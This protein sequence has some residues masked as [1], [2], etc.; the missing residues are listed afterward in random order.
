MNLSCCGV[1]EIRGLSEHTSAVD[2]FRAFGAVTCLRMMTD[3]TGKTCLDKS[4]KPIPDPMER[5]RYVIFTQA[6]KPDYEYGEG[7]AAFLKGNM[8]GQIQETTFN[9]NPNSGNQLKVWLWTID[10]D[11]VKAWFQEDAKARKA[12]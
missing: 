3:S 2:A 6:R 4:G 11:T 9:M 12:A 10:W 5:F 1:K 8:R 7:F